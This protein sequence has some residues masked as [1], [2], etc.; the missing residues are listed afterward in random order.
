MKC[1]SK[2]RN[3]NNCRNHRVGETRFCKLHQYMNEYTDA[4][5]AQL[6][7]CSGCL[8]MYYMGDSG[9]ICCVG[10]RSREKLKPPVILCKSEN[11]KFKRSNENEYCGKHQICLFI[12]E[13]VSRDKK[14]CVNY[15]R[16]CRSQ[17]DTTYKYTRCSGCL[18]T[19]REKDRAR[20]VKVVE[21]NKQVEKNE[22]SPDYVKRIKEMT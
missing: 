16:G 4:M 17:L 20:R 5:L 12:D 11:C 19:D 9:F 1:L 13:T 22:H 21:Q 6:R 2:D 3:H 7:L 18:E 15:V 14:V 8:K 10:C